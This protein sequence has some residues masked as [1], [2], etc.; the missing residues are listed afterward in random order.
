M[1]NENTSYRSVGNDYFHY[2]TARCS[3]GFV[4][5]AVSPNGI[6]AILLGNTREELDQ[7]IRSEFPDKEP[8]YGGCELEGIGAQTVNA[9]EIPRAHISVPL[10]LVGTAAEVRVWQVLQSVPAGDLITYEQIAQRLG[11]P[12]TPETV[13]L[14]CLANRI[15]V[16]IP[17]HRAV[18]S[19]GDIG[20]YRWGV[21]RKRALLVRELRLPVEL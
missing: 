12:H 1:W 2:V 5:T 19:R 9:V 7:A 17:C 18:T 21:E 11:A 6:C 16:G 8:A 4:L 3:L 13:T 15:A 10:H 14:A 20:A